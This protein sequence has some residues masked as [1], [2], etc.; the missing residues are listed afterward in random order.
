LRER[1]REGGREGGREGEREEKQEKSRWLLGAVNAIK[2]KLTEEHGQLKR[3]KNLPK[4]LKF[5]VRRGGDP[6]QPK[7][8]L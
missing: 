4:S 3:T 8:V 1:E 5:M 6:L 7:Q 2:R